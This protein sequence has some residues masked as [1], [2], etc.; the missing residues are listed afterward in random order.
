[1]SGQ[2]D[3]DLSNLYSVSEYACV[4]RKMLPVFH[5]NLILLVMPTFLHKE[6][7]VYLSEKWN[8][9]APKVGVRKKLLDLK[10]VHKNYVQGNL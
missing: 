3:Q 8:R 7:M 2:G 1:M 9:I 6:F 10:K 4:F 5:K